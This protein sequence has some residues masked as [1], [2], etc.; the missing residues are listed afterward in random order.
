MSE[1]QEFWNVDGLL[2]TSVCDPVVVRQ[3]MKRKPEKGEVIVASYPKCG[4]T[5]VGMIVLL[6]KRRGE[7]FKT[8]KEW[9]GSMGFME[10]IPPAML[11]R[12]LTPRCLKT[13]VPFDRLTYSPDAKYIYITRHP[14]DCLVSYYHF[15]K[16]VP[17]HD[18]PDFDQV[19]DLFLAG[20]LDYNDYFDHLLSWYE[21]RHLPN[22]L[23]LTYESAKKDPKGVVLQIAE[24]LDAGFV[25]ELLADEESLLKKILHHSSLESM[26]SSINRYYNIKYF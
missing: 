16:C 24:F 1:R 6:L 4:T 8:S 22:V 15:M 7:P 9:F 14:A 21:H 13:H 18:F 10:N 3:A 5:W 2:I 26:K 12:M 19:F 17:Y 23:F 20:Q 25:P 11:D